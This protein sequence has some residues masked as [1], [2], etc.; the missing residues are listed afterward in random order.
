MTNPKEPLPAV[1]AAPGIASVVDAGGRAVVVAPPGTGKSTALPSALLGKEQPP[2]K[3]N[4]KKAKGKREAHYK[5]I[6]YKANKKNEKN[7]K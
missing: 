1:D 3:D 2:R 5:V 4:R 7:E 6:L